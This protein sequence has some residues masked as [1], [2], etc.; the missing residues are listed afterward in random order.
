VSGERDLH[1]LL[2][3]MDPVLRP[4]AF[5]FVVVPDEPRLDTLSPEATVREPEGLSAVVR[6]EQ[7]DA[8]GLPYDYVAA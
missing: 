7:A 5:V 6:R 3:S 8:L 2:A 4:G 1:R